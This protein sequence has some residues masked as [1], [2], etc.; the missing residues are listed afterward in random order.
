MAYSRIVAT[1]EFM[2]RYALAPSRFVPIAICRL[3]G[4]LTTLVDVVQLQPNPRFRPD[5]LASGK[6]WPVQRTPSPF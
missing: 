2:S 1:K 4:S 6:S 3:N 5:P